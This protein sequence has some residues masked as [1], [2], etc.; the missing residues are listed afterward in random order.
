MENKSHAL[1][2]GS[3]VLLLLT[4]L[5][6]TAVWLTRDTRAM[7]EYL[8]S[9]NVNVTGLQPQASVRYHGVP[10]GKVTAIGLDPDARAQVLVRIAVDDQAPITSSTFATLGVQGVT[11]LAFIA[12]DDA[13]PTSTALATGTEQ[14][15]RI[16]LRAGLMNRLTDQGE[17]L[18][19]QLEQSG[20]RLN[21]LLSPENQRTLMTAVNNLGQAAADLQQ[22]SAQ[23]RQ[24]WPALAKSGQETLAALQA[25]SQRVGDSA[26]EARASA[27]AFRRVT[28]RMYAPGGTLDKL[29]WGADVLVATGQ[30][31]HNSTLPAVQQAVQ[32][33]ARTT[34]QI[35]EL[36]QAFSDQ[37][38]ALLLGKP[39]PHPGPGE[40]GFMAPAP[41]VR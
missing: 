41:A 19:G 24:S 3:F 5:T 36:A 31:L 32:A 11:G 2:A 9:G 21:A 29:D 20:Q 15:A 17:R 38:Q 33:A 7:R 13:T 4:L 34:R 39:T 25:T 28:E 10:V 30:T 27:L 8:L 37:P 26:N 22:L 14:P 40:P 6:A 35:G 12:L 23:A 18:L 1:A 16:P